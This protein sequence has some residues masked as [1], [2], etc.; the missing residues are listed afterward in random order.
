MLRALKDLF[1]SVDNHFDLLD[2]FNNLADKM[3]KGL[4]KQYLG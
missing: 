2:A 1:H 4:K 3:F